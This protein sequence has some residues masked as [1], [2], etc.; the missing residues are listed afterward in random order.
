MGSSGIFVTMQIFRYW[1]NN[2]IITIIIIIKTIIIKT[3]I[4]I[5]IIIVILMSIKYI[6]WVA[7]HLDY[8]TIFTILTKITKVKKYKFI[9]KNLNYIKH[10][11]S[12]C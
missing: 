4:I 10:K 12:K 7:L 1:H 8:A 5:T 3:I 2:I 11:L 9:H 6:H